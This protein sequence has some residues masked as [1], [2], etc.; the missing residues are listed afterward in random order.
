[1]AESYTNRPVNYSDLIYRHLDR[2]SDSLRRGIEV[3][4]VK[5]ATFLMSYYLFILHFESL[6][7]TRI[8]GEAYERIKEYKQRLP[9]FRLAWSG[10]LKENIDFLEAISQWFQVL[11]IVANNNNFIQ[12]APKLWDEYKDE[13]DKEMEAGDSKNTPN[14]N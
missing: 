2:M 13:T 12:I 6:I 8:E 4:E 7:N 9:S 1:M 5:N 14:N 10:N 11:L 3:G